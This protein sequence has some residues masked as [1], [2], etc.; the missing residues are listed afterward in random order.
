VLAA[1]LIILWVKEAIILYRPPRWD[2]NRFNRWQGPS[3]EVKAIC[4]HLE[5]ISPLNGRLL[6]DD[7]RVGTLLPWCSGVEVIGGPFPFTWTKYGYSNANLWTFL[8]RPYREIDLQSWRQSVRLYN[9]E[10]LLI[11]TNWGV[12][13]WFTLSDWLTLHPQ[14]VQPGPQFGIYQFYKVAAF[15]P[16]SRMDITADHGALQ[17]QNATPGRS[18]RLP[19]HWIS[20]LKAWP[21]GSAE[22]INETVGSD[23]IPFIV[24][25]PN[26]ESF[27][28][29]DPTGCP[30]K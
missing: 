8:D 9:I 23:P 2:G 5:T 1:I 20:T 14:E 26:Q 18:V 21:P 11:N 7:S 6:V 15:E 24:I 28:I 13:E 30:E 16:D 12:A 25:T 19:Y 10:W 27:L 17:I 3:E 4:G 22:L 29:C